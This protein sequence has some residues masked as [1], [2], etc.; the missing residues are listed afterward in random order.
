M[1]DQVGEAPDQ[2]PDAGA[3]AAAAAGLSGV[4]VR[5]PL[6]EAF[7]L[8]DKLG[9]RLLVKAECLQRTGSFKFRGAYNALSRITDH[10]KAK[11]VVAF[12]SGNHGQA[13]AAAARLLGLAAYVVMPPDASPH[14][15]AAT[16]EHGAEVELY[17]GYYVDRDDHVRRIA[18]RSGAVFIPPF[19]HPDVVAGQATVGMEIGHDLAGSDIGAVYVCCS[20]GGLV[21][22]VGLALR[23]THPATRIVAVEPA[24]YDDMGRSLRA[25]H[26]VRNGA[27]PPTLCDALKSPMPGR[28]T[29]DICRSLG[30]E[31]RMVGD[32]DVMR[33]VML[34]FQTLQLVVEPS[35]AV[36]LAAAL[37]DAKELTGQTVIVIVSGGN[38]EPGLYGCAL[39]ASS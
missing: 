15:I 27:A 19:D 17:D 12:S 22:G 31:A 1:A 38:V 14:K 39:Q 4:A 33:A 11:G 21:A 10:Q 2:A 7:A 16:R 35:G 26:R 36:A 6:I 29:F 9:L 20:G 8:S 24:G 25:G 32:E 30:V 37:N 23:A 18:A 28:L 5:T 13:V 34:A 3:I